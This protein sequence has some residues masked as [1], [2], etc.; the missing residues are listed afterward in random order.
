[1]KY[2]V[3]EGIAVSADFSQFDFISMGKRGPIHKRVAFAITEMD[4]IHNL[5]FGDVAE[6]GEIDD[7]SVSDNGDRNKVLA[8]VVNIVTSYTTR[9]PDRWILFQGSTDSRTRLYRMAIGLYLE[10]LSIKFEIYAFVDELL[11]PFC[12]NMKVSAFVI[13]KK[14]T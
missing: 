5:A 10:E 3:Y 14:N 8:T 6:D 12:K 1:M 2:E 11:I 9:Y 4:N 13:R 7:L